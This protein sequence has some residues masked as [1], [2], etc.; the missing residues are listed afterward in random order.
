[1]AN[2]NKLSMATELLSHNN[3]HTVSGF[4]GLSKK[5]VYTP[6]GATVSVNRYNYNPEAIAHLQR[7]I[8][9][10]G[11]GL[12]AAVK[13]CRVQKLEIGNIEL[14]A[15]ISADKRF[16]ALQLLQFIDYTYQPISRVAIYEGE[17]AQLVATIFD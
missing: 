2:F 14:D 16:V 12:A 3:L 6:T 10:D 8:D 11:K 9:S 1:M 15:C 4:M 13:A 7:V 17:Q 5:L